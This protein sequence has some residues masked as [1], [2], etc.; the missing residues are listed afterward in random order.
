MSVGLRRRFIVNISHGSGGS[1]V[2][3]YIH[4]TWNNNS[5]TDRLFQSK[6]TGGISFHSRR[7]NVLVKVEQ[8]SMYIRK[9]DSSTE[10]PSGMEIRQ[11][12]PSPFLQCTNRELLSSLLFLFLFILRAALP[13]DRC[14]DCA[15]TDIFMVLLPMCE[16]NA[17]ARTFWL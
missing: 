15:R 3:T 10:R 16:K 4:V 12:I 17:S 13:P 11:R 14:A 1:H 6:E 9:A 7:R 5:I 2:Y 8:H